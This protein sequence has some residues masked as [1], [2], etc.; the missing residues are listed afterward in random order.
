[1]GFESLLR[2]LK[3]TSPVAAGSVNDPLRTLDGNIRY[4]RELFDAASLGSTVY[5][6]QVTVEADA[7]VGMPVWFNPTTARF[8]RGLAIVDPTA[9]NG[10]LVTAPSAQIWGVIGQK[11]NATLADV[12]LYGFDTIDITAAAGTTAAGTYYLSGVTPGGLVAQ[13]PPVSVAVLRATGDGRVF[14]VTQFLDFLDRHT[15]Y[16]FA[17]VCEPAGDTSAPAPGERHFIS[18]TNPAAPGWLPANDPTFE[19]HAPPGAAFGYNLKADPALLAAWPPLPAGQAEL[20]WDKGTDTA[21]G[22]TSVSTGPGGL[23]QVDRYGIWWMSDCYG[24]VPWPLVFTRSDSSAF[25]DSSTIECPRQ[26]EM[27]LTLWFTKARFITDTTAVTSLHSNDSRVVIRCQGTDTPASAGPLDIALDLNLVADDAAGDGYLVFKELVGETFRRGPVVE[28]IYTESTR[29]TLSSPVR[30]RLVTGDNTSPWL[31]QGPVDI[32]ISDQPT[33]ELD[34]QLVRLDGAEEVTFEDLLYLGF[35]AGEVRSFRAVFHI[36]GDAGVA[37]P[38][39]TLRYRILGRA[40][41]TLP[42][43]TFTAR[44]VP[45]PANGLATP[46]TLPGTG[47]EFS[48]T[49][50]TTAVLATANQYVEAESTPFTVADGDTVYVT[51]ERG[52]DGYAS[53]VGVLQQVAILSS[54]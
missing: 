39:L 43:L 50:V 24:D 37:S 29:L 13:Q 17:L 11:T 20:I 8:E 30:R 46:L 6:R 4:L 45:R 40:A 3:T 41:G 48:V 32:E 28:G 1:M 38:Q 9:V 51:V 18:S 42:Q 12:L 2:L 10:V 25:S 5:A 35:A 33:F 14:V 31:Y 16:R 27:H 26:L 19:G 15:H 44:R 7:L 23:A 49:C 52:V 53:E 36:P 54:G 34:P 22:G 47:L 21:V